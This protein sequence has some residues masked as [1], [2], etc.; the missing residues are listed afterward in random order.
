MVRRTDKHSRKLLGGRFHGRGYKNRQAM[1]KGG[2]GG[3]GF[4][5]CKHLWVK[6]IKFFPDH[7][8]KH[9]FHNPTQE[10][11]EVM[12]VGE[13]CSSLEHLL[14]SKQVEMQGDAVKVDLEKLGI[15]KL[16]GFGEVNCKLIVVGP[17]SKSA[18]EKI[19]K[20]GGKVN[21]G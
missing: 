13:L 6:T 3:K 19:E 15:G 4:A 20:A 9:G 16:L 18:I 17:A 12:N 10:K 21:A 2:K 7:F 8:G 5:W 11:Y 14:A 1:G